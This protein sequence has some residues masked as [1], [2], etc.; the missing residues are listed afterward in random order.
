MNTTLTDQINNLSRNEKLILI[1]KLWDS[2]ISEPENVP[3]PDFHKKI[4]DERHKTF[5]K[6]RAEG[7][8]WTEVRKKY[9]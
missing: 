1:E 2:I 6:D 9:L 4:L 3:F 8:P 7:T 5:E